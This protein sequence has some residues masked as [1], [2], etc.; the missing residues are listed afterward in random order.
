MAGFVELSLMRIY[1]LK[2]GR[3]LVHPIGEPLLPEEQFAYCKA[4]QSKAK[5]F[6]LPK[7]RFHVLSLILRC[8]IKISKL[9]V[10]S[11]LN[12]KVTP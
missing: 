10:D 5:F 9:T 1:F 8:L 11:N 2:T 12:T 4:S 6:P 3:K 7:L